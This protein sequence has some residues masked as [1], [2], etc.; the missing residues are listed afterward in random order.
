M[1][2]DPDMARVSAR[3]PE[4]WKEEESCL[5]SLGCSYFGGQS[6]AVDGVS[7]KVADYSTFVGQN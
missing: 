4:S 1:F 6:A 7:S 2:A 3:V 5:F